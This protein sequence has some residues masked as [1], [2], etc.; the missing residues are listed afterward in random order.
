MVAYMPIV[1]I[2]SALFI[3]WTLR[4]HLPWLLA[5]VGS[6]TA[7]AASPFATT[8]TTTARQE[9]VS[10]TV[11]S[12]IVSFAGHSILARE[13]RRTFVQ[14]LQLRGVNQTA[15]RQRRELEALA[16][17]LEAVARR[18][19]L[20]GV[21]NRL[22]LDEDVAAMGAAG[23][24]AG[25]V[26]AV[27]LL[28]IDHFKAYN[29]ENGHLAGDDVLREVARAIA[30]DLRPQDRV[31]RFGGE[32][33]LVLLD[34]VDAAGGVEVA[35]R[36]RLAIEALAIPLP[37]NVPW[38]ILTSSAGVATARLGEGRSDDWIRAADA[39]LYAAKAAGR[40]CVV[41]PP[42]AREARTTRADSSAA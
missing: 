10:I 26:A 38:G 41:G 30:I 16:A 3:P 8:L 5:V 35:E 34:G 29:D 6:V 7:F 28:D 40:N 1:I 31:Y 15:R 17:Q 36:L 37:A 25:E 20:T 9:L 27:V 42:A 22:R 19:P 11:T 12:A 14:R 2:A 32:E 18:D 24:L 4:W 13:R 33:F 23:A 21:G 39:R